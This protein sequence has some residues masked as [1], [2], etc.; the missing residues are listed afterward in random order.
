MRDDPDSLGSIL[1]GPHG[2][3]YVAVAVCGILASLAQ[4]AHFRNAER[5]F[6]ERGEVRPVLLFQPTPQ[7]KVPADESSLPQPAERQGD[8]D[9]AGTF[10]L[11]GDPKRLGATVRSTGRGTG[12]GAVR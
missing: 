9:A 5:A 11:A 12:E 3:V 7:F 1:A 8:T 10:G 6:R 2:G 4:K